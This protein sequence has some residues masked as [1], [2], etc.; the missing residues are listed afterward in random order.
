[1]KPSGRSALVIRGCVVLMLAACGLGAGAGTVNGDQEG[2]SEAEAFLAAVGYPPEGF[3]VLIAWSEVVPGAEPGTCVLGYRVQP[4]AGGEPFDLYSAA[5]GDLLE[6]DQLDALGIQAKNWDLPPVE[7]PTV[8]PEPVGKALPPPPVPVSDLLDLAPGDE[9]ALPPV[10]MAR[11]RAEDDRRAREPGAKAHRIGVFRKLPEPLAIDA[12][13]PCRGTWQVLPDGGHLWA[14]TIFSPDSVG[15]RIHFQAIDLPDGAQV[16]VFNAGDPAE[17]YGPYTDSLGP[18]GDLWSATCFAERVTVECHVPPGVPRDAVTLVIDRIVHVYADFG[19]LLEPKAAGSCNLDVTCYP[20]WSTTASAIAGIGTIGID[21]MIWCTGTLFADSIPTTDVPYFVTANHC[22]DSQ[23]AAS[24]A[25]IYW[26]YQTAECD[27]ANPPNLT[28]VP[29]SAS[30]ADFLAGASDANGTDFTLLQLRDTP[31]DGIAFAGWSS[32]LAAVGAD[33]VCIHHPSGDYK[34]ISFGHIASTDEYLHEVLWD[35]GTTEPGSSGS[36]L[37]L[38]DS[39]LF[40]GQLYGGYASCSTPNEPDYYG[41]FDLSYPLVDQ[42]LG[43]EAPAFVVPTRNVTVPFRSGTAT[44]DI[45]DNGLAAL[46][47]EAQVTDGAEWL[48]IT[49]GASGTT[50]GALVVDYTRNGRSASRTG[51][52]VVT[53]Q[54]GQTDATVTL[55]VTQDPSS[56]SCIGL[57]ARTSTVGVNPPATVT[58]DL[59]LLA[60]VLVLL[61]RSS[62]GDSE[63]T[64]YVSGG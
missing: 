15:Q 8:V 47:W 13:G 64:P 54:G 59:L 11:V 49:A 39:Q 1:V 10:D 41:R 55:T 46:A 2:L 53:A 30:G 34:R 61:A 57:P 25:E 43:A 4:R 26:L 20:D 16:V 27:A 42:W 24:A 12:A 22:I 19:A 35:E 23:N 37:L 5:A 31:P 21:G 18:D 48:S 7:T 50:P 51:Q 45:Q 3:A 44:F 40:V 17:A 28:S 9:V 60:A 56:V 62:I 33:M 29:R 52:I 38:P 32:D 63:V 58:A 36:P 14:A 6:Q